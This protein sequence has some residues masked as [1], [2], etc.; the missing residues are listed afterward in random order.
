M[1]QQGPP[2]IP[3][4]AELTDGFFDRRVNGGAFLCQDDGISCQ[5]GFIFDDDRGADIEID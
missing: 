5:P 3:Y 1:I 2:F 4:R